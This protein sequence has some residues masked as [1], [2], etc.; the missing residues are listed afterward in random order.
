MSSGQPTEMSRPGLQHSLLAGERQQGPPQPSFI[1]ALAEVSVRKPKFSVLSFLGHDSKALG[2]L[3]SFQLPHG[4]YGASGS[5]CWFS[6]RPAWGKRSC[7]MR[8]MSVPLNRTQ[9][10]EPRC[11]WVWPMGS[12]MPAPRGRVGCALSSHPVSV[13]GSVFSTLHGSP[14]AEHSSS[15]SSAWL[16]RCSAEGAHEFRIHNIHIYIL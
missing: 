10:Q 4:H 2:V 15:E 13:P 14:L 7:C 12:S 3:F 1:W 6:P 8:P 11:F 9:G 16:P 5:L